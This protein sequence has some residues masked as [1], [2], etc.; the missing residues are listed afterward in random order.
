MSVVFDTSS[1]S[2]KLQERERF[3][4]LTTGE[5]GSYGSVRQHESLN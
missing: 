1:W 2:V 4:T 3:V 5:W